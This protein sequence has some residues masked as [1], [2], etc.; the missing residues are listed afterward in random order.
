MYEYRA[1][2]V[3][4]VDGDTIDVETDLGFNIDF[5]QRL[6]LYGINAPEL[7]TPEG[8]AAR[9]FIIGQ[10]PTAQ[11]ALTI[12]TVK[13]KQE[14]YGR[15]LATIFVGGAAGLTNINDLMVTSGHAVPYFP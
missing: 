13:D 11:W 5:T 14:K 3:R 15:Y 2:L 8:L 10:L 6:R 9:A 12:D 7:S 4:V 1:T